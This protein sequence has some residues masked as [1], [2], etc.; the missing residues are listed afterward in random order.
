[1]ESTVPFLCKS[2]QV[3]KCQSYLDLHM[4]PPASFFDTMHMLQCHCNK[5]ARVSLLKTCNNS[6]MQA[7]ANPC[8]CLSL[9]GLCTSVYMQCLF[10]NTKDS[11][12]TIDRCVVGKYSEHAFQALD[13]ILDEASKYGVRLLLTLVNNWDN[14]DSKTQVQHLHALLSW[15]LVRLSFNPRSYQHNTTAVLPCIDGARYCVQ[16]LVKS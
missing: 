7:I 10:I 16:S 9:S 1:M 4:H 6:L 11:L 15:M 3:S 5:E 13:Y 8:H 2:E 12:M 14:A